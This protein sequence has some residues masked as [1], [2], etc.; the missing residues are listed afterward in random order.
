MCFS[1]S[2]FIELIYHFI[3]VT[4]LTPLLSLLHKVFVDDLHELL[5]S[6]IK[7]LWCHLENIR[8]V[9]QEPVRVLAFKYSEVRVKKGA[10]RLK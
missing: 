1:L 2:V 6:L 3:I 8:L 4:L 10:I 5:V 7:H 9:K